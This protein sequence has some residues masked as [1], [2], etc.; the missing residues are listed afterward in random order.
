MQ[1]S[2]PFYD[3]HTCRIA[4]HKG[5]KERSGGGGKKEK[6]P[7]S[8]EPLSSGFTDLAPDPLKRKKKK[9]AE[10]EKEKKEGKWLFVPSHY[11]NSPCGQI[12]GKGGK[13]GRGERKSLEEGEGKGK[14]NLMECAHSI[15]YFYPVA[16]SLNGGVNKRDRERRK[17]GGEGI[18]KERGKDRKEREKEKEKKKVGETSEGVEKM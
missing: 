3:L 5:G 9:K 17:R 2:S 13:R 6:D 7:H 16:V 18:T 8:T 12:G 14:E 1:N 4:S 10:E 11:C 15:L